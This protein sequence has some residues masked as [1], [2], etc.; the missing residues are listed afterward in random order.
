ML[1]PGL[2][3]QDWY[4]GVREIATK[5]P[6]LIPKEHLRAELQHTSALKGDSVPPVSPSL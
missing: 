5:S 4:D 1:F 3:P 6:R 2:W